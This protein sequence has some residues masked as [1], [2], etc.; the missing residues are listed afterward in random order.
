MATGEPRG[1]IW[2][3]SLPG[4]PPTVYIR[5]FDPLS[6][7]YWERRALGVKPLIA[8]PTN[9]ETNAVR[10]SLNPA[11]PAF[12]SKTVASPLAGRH[13]RSEGGRPVVSSQ[14]AAGRMQ[15][16]LPTVVS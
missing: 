12:G 13:A 7:Q 6:E 15:M 4:G 2:E 16:K 10:L 3:T 11:Q 5:S 8:L 9:P 14:P 1:G